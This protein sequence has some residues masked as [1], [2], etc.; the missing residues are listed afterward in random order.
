M[1]VAHKADGGLSVVILL[2][3][4]HNGLCHSFKIFVRGQQRLTDGHLLK[5][6]G[7]LGYLIHQIVVFETTHQMGGLHHQRLDTIIHR[8][9][10][11]FRHIVDGDIISAL[12]MVND[13][14]AGK[15]PAHAVVRAGIGN[16]ALNG[17]DGQS[18]AVIIAGAEADDQQLPLPDLI[19]VARIVQAGVPRFVVFFFL[20]GSGQLPRLRKLPLPS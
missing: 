16:G 2:R 14:L 3:C 1:P 10:Q 12:Y 20:L 8:T 19:L 9:I 7:I 6:I 18:A 5:G 11:C 17:T 4:V 15:S 13:N